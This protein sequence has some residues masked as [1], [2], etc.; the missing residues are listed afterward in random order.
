MDIK[1]NVFNQQIDILSDNNEYNYW[2]SGYYIIAENRYT[3]DLSQGHTSTL[4]YE[5]Y[6]IKKRSN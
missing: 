4:N 6:K 5:I 3:C 1:L 2:Q